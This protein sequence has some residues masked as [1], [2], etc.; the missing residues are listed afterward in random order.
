[1]LNTVPDNF[2]SALSF[3]SFR[4]RLKTSGR[5]SDS[6]VVRTSVDLAAFAVASATTIKIRRWVLSRH[7]PGGAGVSRRLAHVNLCDIAESPVSL[8][9]NHIV[10]DCWRILLLF[11]SD[12]AYWHCVAVY[13]AEAMQE[14]TYYIWSNKYCVCL[15]VNSW[16]KGR[17][18]V[19]RRWS[20]CQVDSPSVTN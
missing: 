17:S 12:I 18:W 3:D 9:Q 14:L 6:L 8:L 4:R 15:R 11:Y 1:M 5:P 10:C 2:V 7:S 16:L 13:V 20:S 19:L